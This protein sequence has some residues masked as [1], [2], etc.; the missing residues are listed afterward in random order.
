MILLSLFTHLQVVA[1]KFRLIEQLLNNSFGGW[2][3]RAIHREV[4]SR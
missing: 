4:R 2:P 3:L 1:A